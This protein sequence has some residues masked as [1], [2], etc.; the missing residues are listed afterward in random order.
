MPLV[1]PVVVECGCIVVS[2]PRAVVISHDQLSSK[3]ACCAVVLADWALNSCILLVSILLCHAATT[4]VIARGQLRY[5]KREAKVATKKQQQRQ[6]ACACWARRW[7]NITSGIGCKA[8]IQ[9]T[10]NNN[11]NEVFIERLFCALSA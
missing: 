3:L 5:S 11:D 10:N 7:C 9:N 4:P 1:N 8:D 6:G 2:V